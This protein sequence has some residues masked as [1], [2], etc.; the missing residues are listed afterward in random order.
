MPVADCATYA[1]IRHVV[2]RFAEWKGLTLLGAVAIG[3][4]PID[5]V[6]D[7]EYALGQ[8]PADNLFPNLPPSVGKIAKALLEAEEPLG[9]SEIID[10][11]GISGSTYDRRISELEAFDFVERNGDRK[12]DIHLS[13]WFV[14]EGNRSHPDFDNISMG[15]MQGVLWEVIDPEE[16]DDDVCEALGDLDS[17]VLFNRF[18]WL[19][20]WWDVL[21]TLTA[22]LDACRDRGLLGEDS[23]QIRLGDPPPESDTVQTALR[24]SP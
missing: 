17:T 4:C 12:W 13:P 10:R 21:E 3:T 20:G 23:R 7:F 19:R 11:A 8:L 6:S 18:P 14:G 2:E 22:H 15:G 16:L 9:R 1:G 24:I 5:P